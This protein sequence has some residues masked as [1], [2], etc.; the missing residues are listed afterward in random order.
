MLD[1]PP[2][3][4]RSPDISDDF[5]RTLSCTGRDGSKQAI[6]ELLE[7]CR[8]YLTL[9]AN[10]ELDTQLR[11][12]AGASDLV[13]E[14]FLEAQQCY[15]Q[16][17]GETEAD[18]LA[19]LRGILLHNLSDFVRR[20]QGSEKRRVSRERR[21][22]SACEECRRVADRG[23]AP[24]AE[25]TTPS[26]WVMRKERIDMLRAALA[27]LRDNDR[28]VLSLRYQRG[29]TF[30]EI[31]QRMQRSPDAARMLWTRALKRLHCELDSLDE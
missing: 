30:A 29:M 17:S 25:A 26:G 21:L 3:A 13:Q 2:H 20:Y 9:I 19:W 22:D 12:K 7:R 10:R 14:T 23:L 27:R 6:G 8:Q 24:A 5:F 1:Q 11:P 18:L 15:E 28:R 16:F 4:S 31:G